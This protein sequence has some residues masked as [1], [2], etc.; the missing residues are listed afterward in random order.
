MPLTLSADAIAEK[1]KLNSSGAWLTLLEIGYPD[2]E[3]PDVVYIVANNSE[4]ITWPS[5]GGNEYLAYPVTVGPITQESD[6][7]IPTLDMTVIDILHNL[8]PI[9]DEYDGG[10]GATVTIRIVHSDHLDNVDA[11]YNETFSVL[12]ASYNSK[13]ELKFQLGADNPLMYR[14]PQD[15]YIKDH[16]RYKTFKGTECGYVGVQ[17]SCDRTFI[18]C[19]EYGNEGRFGGFPGVGSEAYNA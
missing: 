14:I 11:E 1:N 16:C 2:A 19:R 13:Y 18:Q 5:S 17:T 3:P 4:N 10:V 12:T 6:G 9:I 8:I 7:G 15:R